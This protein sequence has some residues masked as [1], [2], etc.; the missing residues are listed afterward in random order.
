MGSGATDLPRRNFF[1]EFSGTLKIDLKQQ[2]SSTVLSII[3]NVWERLYS[4]YCIHKLFHYFLYPLECQIIE[5]LYFL[6]VGLLISLLRINNIDGSTEVANENNNVSFGIVTFINNEHDILPG[7]LRYHSSF[8][9]LQNIVILDNNSTEP[10]IDTL[11]AWEKKGIRVLYEQGPYSEK[12]TLTIKAIKEYLAHVDVIIPLDAD[13]ILTA[14]DGQ[15]LIFKKSFMLERLKEFSESN[16]SC[17]ALQQYFPSKVYSS[18]ETLENIQYFNRTE[19]SVH[20]AKK[21][22]K[23]QDLVGLDHGSHHPTIRGRKPCE[24]VLGKL[25]LLHYHNRNPK[26]TVLRA[27]TAVN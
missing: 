14:F 16:H 12:G 15:E 19:Y 3:Q 5:M 2:C 26:L 17:W 8:T 22:V 4:N 23:N 21:I 24:S 9:P 10:T 11:R 20:N 27:L 7:W 13:E 6:I 1:S 25:G 18:N